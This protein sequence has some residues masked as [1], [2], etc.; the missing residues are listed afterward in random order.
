MKYFIN[1]LFAFCILAICTN[2]IA[3]NRKISGKIISAKDNSPVAA[4]T[5]SVKGKSQSVAANA[6]GSFSLNVPA[7]Q[8]T[9]LIS[10]VGFAPKEF[11]VDAASSNIIITLN[12]DFS[13]LSDVVVVGYG[14]QKKSDLTGAISSIKGADVTQLA[15]QRVD[16]ALQG[17]AAGVL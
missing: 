12:E 13:Q 14:T 16:Q 3:Q 11:K 15:T 1:L 5:I 8:V 9:L 2:G 17:R 4:A 6:D 7:G 10:S